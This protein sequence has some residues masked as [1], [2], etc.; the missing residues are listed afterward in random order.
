MVED[1]LVVDGVVADGLAV[2]VVWPGAFV[3]FSNELSSDRR[4]VSCDC[5]ARYEDNNV[6]LVEGFVAQ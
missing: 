1:E 6:S 4:L 2:G 5:C 3:W